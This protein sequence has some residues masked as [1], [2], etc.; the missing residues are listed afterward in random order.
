MNTSNTAICSITHAILTIQLYKNKALS[1]SLASR[2]L[3]ML[4]AAYRLCHG[5]QSSRCVLY[6]DIS[7]ESEINWGIVRHT[8]WRRSLHAIK[9]FPS[10]FSIEVICKYSADH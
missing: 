9:Q 6:D 5:T 1:L 10:S 7:G 3:L 4:R 8:F 2:K